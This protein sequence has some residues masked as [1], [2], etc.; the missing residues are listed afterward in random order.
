MSTQHPTMN[1]A[2]THCAVHRLPLKYPDRPALGCKSCCA[3]RL[4]KNRRLFEQD[5][6]SRKQGGK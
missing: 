6:K 4:E 2:F 1:L 5:L 3:E